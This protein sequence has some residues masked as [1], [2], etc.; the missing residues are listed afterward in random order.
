MYWLL[1]V[2]VYTCIIKRPMHDSVFC[3]FFFF[4]FTNKFQRSSEADLRN[5]E[6]KLHEAQ[7]E[8]EKAEIEGEFRKGKGH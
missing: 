2:L 6:S 8:R 7:M 5:L 3:S 4:D 1:F